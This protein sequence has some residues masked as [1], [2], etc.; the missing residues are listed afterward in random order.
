MDRLLMFTD[1]VRQ[2]RRTAIWHMRNRY[3]PAVDAGKLSSL[4]STRDLMAM[5]ISEK[6][7]H[8]GD[9]YEYLH[10]CTWQMP[11]AVRE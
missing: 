2:A 7:A 11:E 4:T 10:A 3:V 5:Q 9:L 6:Q 8:I 1:G